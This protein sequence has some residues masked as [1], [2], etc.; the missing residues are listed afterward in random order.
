MYRLFESLVYLLE[1][2]WDESL[3]ILEFDIV[4]QGQDVVYIL[5][6]IYI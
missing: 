6:S 5:P 1:E 3:I 2:I 4:N